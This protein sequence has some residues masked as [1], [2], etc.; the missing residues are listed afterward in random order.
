[1]KTFAGLFKKYRLRSEFETI[2]AFGNALSKKGY[3]YEESIFSHWQKGTRTP[4]NRNVVLAMLEVFVERGAI[5]TRE[6]ANEFLATTGL[7]YLT[8]QE[9]RKLQIKQSSQAPF[10][11]PCEI[12]NFTGR[13]EIL[14]EIK[15]GI[16]PGKIFLLH[17]SPG[18]GK[19]ALAIKLGHLLRGKFPD[20]VLWYKVDSTNA[21]DILLSIG[22][23][24]GEDMQ[25]I[26][27]VKVRSSIVR[28]LLENKRLLLI[29]DNVTGVD[30]LH[31][32]LPNIASCCV[33]FTAQE[34]VLNISAEYISYPVKTFSKA[35]TLDL[36]GKI[37]DKNYLEKHK[38]QILIISEKLGNL[39]LAVHI[40]AAYCRQFNISLEKYI[41]QLDAESF[42]LQELK[43]EDKNLLRAISIGFTGMDQKTREIFISLGVFEGKDFSLDAVAFINKIAVSETKQR[44][45]Q[46]QKISFLEVSG[47]NR[48]RLHPLIKLFARKQ[49][50][51]NSVYLRTAIYYEQLLV[52]AQEKYSH[53]TLR[54][55][56]DNIVY[57]FKKCY[58]LE[59]WDVIITLWNPLEKFLSDMNEIKKLRLLTQTIDTSPRVNK[60]QKALTW[61]FIFMIVIWLV[62]LM[63]GLKKGLWNNLYSLF[64]S[65]IPLFSGTVGILGSN[66]WGRFKSNIG[67]AVLFLSAGMF[68]WGVGN[69]IWGYY[70]FFK[71]IDVPYP[72]FADVGYLPAYLFWIFG[73]IHLARSTGAKFSSNKNKLVLLLIPVTV[74][75]LSFYIFFFVI[76]REFIYENPIKLFFDIY[77]PLMDAIILTIAVI[78]FG[79]SVNFFGG[80]YKLSVLAILVGFV[81]MYFADLAFSYAISLNTYYNGGHTDIIFIFAFYLM[82]WGTLSFHLTP[83]R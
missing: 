49:I 64:I 32:L 53:K 38:K 83:K 35:E 76:K 51:D 15:K 72:S 36:F 27:D 13:E 2:S 28:T 24:F 31:L 39:P 6:E 12:A 50:T 41:K 66:Y 73:I 75:S 59:Y 70:N 81:M 10:Q 42:D 58:E 71:S 44:V 21:M 68:V 19:T 17:G 46:L 22:R 43:Y 14:A 3:F 67:K 4:A 52:T 7:G 69:L 65:F 79:L 23:L 78:I 11:V 34:N 1:M 54:Q 45:E 8:E 16:T 80:K 77:Y 62:L 37:F 55:E 47:D 56:V 25:S 61:Y 26:K 30:D 82:A 60:L 48:Y 74:V 20:G 63:A 33:I 29:F 9:L 18:V 5:N 40:A 57:I